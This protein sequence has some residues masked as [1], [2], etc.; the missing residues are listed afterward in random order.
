MSNNQNN[1]ANNNSIEGTMLYERLRQIMANGG[2]EA[3]MT[4]SNVMEELHNSRDNTIRFYDIP[5]EGT[6]PQPDTN[7]Y[8]T[9]IQ[10]SQA[11]RER[12]NQLYPPGDNSVWRD[13]RT[14][15]QHPTEQTPHVRVSIQTP[16]PSRGPYVGDRFANRPTRRFESSIGSIHTTSRLIR[17][18]PLRAATEEETR[19][20]MER[21]RRNNN[22]RSN[23]DNGDS[24][25]RSNDSNTATTGNT[26]GNQRS[27]RPA[28]TFLQ[29][30][31]PNASDTPTEHE[32]TIE[33][34]ITEEYER[35]KQAHEARIN[36][37]ADMIHQYSLN[38]HQLFLHFAQC[39]EKARLACEIND[40][41]YSCAHSY[42]SEGL[43]NLVR[44]L[45]P[46]LYAECYSTLSRGHPT[47][48]TDAFIHQRGFIQSNHEISDLIFDYTTLLRAI[49]GIYSDTYY[50]THVPIYVHIDEHNN[51]SFNGDHM[52][53]LSQPYSGPDC[54]IYLHQLK[55]TPENR[56][57]FENEKQMF[58]A[59]ENELWYGLINILRGKYRQFN[60]IPKIKPSVRRYNSS[61]NLKQLDQLLSDGL[62]PEEAAP[63]IITYDRPPF[64]N[65][66]REIKIERA[67]VHMYVRH[68][69]DIPIV[70]QHVHH[71]KPTKD[72][73]YTVKV[74]Y[75]DH[76]IAEHHDE[77]LPYY[78]YRPTSIGKYLAHN[79]I[80]NRMLSEDDC[81][82]IE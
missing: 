16:A 43:Y 4:N 15:N 7:D 9:I 57:A 27:T 72:D 64:R 80:T 52:V 71:F 78:Q 58:K 31:T 11:D 68:I 42:L 54:L 44:I 81:D 33:R 59:L 20:V 60:R 76:D 6:R 21:V 47:M 74:D 46:Q 23:S 79:N 55:H 56:I 66:P 62:T 40:C 8:S 45:D 67:R 34:S 38:H 30:R 18:E 61:D 29:S 35:K 1:A 24:N 14:R 63:V 2:V 17:N 26:N 28:V 69:N 3:Y 5:I 19:E 41:C 13:R 50:Q 49:T 37:I 32:L 82:C 51:I 12:R 10:G 48:K 65:P 36:E 53:T 73:T 39:T 25:E 70:K 75:R 22:E 77:Y